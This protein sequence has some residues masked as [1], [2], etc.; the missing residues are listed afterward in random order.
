MQSSGE[1]MFE[2]RLKTKPWAVRIRSRAAEPQE[3][4]LARDARTLGV[5]VRRIMVAQAR[6]QRAIEAQAPSLTDGYHT[7]E[8]EGRIR[9]TNGDAALPGE[10]FVGMN[11]PGMLML[12]LGAATQY[13]DDG[14]VGRVA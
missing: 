9:W 14:A 13:L 11:G 8:L 4:G 5:A 1:K 3:I 12:K 10:L 2:F 7:Y 6:W